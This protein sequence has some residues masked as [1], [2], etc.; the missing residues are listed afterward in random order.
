MAKIYTQKPNE[1]KLKLERNYSDI[2]TD[3]LRKSGAP[4][5]RIKENRQIFN[6]PANFSYSCL[7]ILQKQNNFAFL[8]WMFCL[9]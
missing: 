7:K 5:L 9:R 4:L 8:I 1:I 2:L 6:Y 3:K